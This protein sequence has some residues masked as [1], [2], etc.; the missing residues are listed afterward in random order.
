[1][2][3]TRGRRRRRPSARASSTTTTPATTSYDVVKDSITIGRGGIAY[4]VDIRIA[5]S[6]DVS[7]EHARH[8]AGS[9]DRPL[10]SDRSELA[11]HDAERAPR[12]EGLRRSRRREARER[13]GN[14]P[15]GRRHD[16]S[17]GHRLPRVRRR[18][19]MTALLLGASDVRAHPDRARRPVR[20]DGL[21][22]ARRTGPG[23]DGLEMSGA[24]MDAVSVAA[25]GRRHRSGTAARGQR[26]PLPRRRSRAGS[27]WSSTASA[28]RRPAARPPTRR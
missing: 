8:P 20:V 2:N 9:E 26:G 24:A 22:I 11:R 23:T 14:R 28:A 12:A 6:P 17:G 4:P 27:S 21:A 5:S 16:R 15:A 1:M 3:R 19:V 7:R 13:R 10:L 25:S 18:A